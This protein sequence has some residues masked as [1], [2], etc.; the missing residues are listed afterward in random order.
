MQSY[1]FSK[2]CIKRLSRNSNGAG[3]IDDAASGPCC[4]RE[5][6]QFDELPCK[7]MAEKQDLAYKLIDE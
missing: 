1:L 7:V 2:R 4:Q 6:L 3:S 5:F